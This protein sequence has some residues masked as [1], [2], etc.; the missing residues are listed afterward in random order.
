MTSTL[1]LQHVH[2]TLLQPNSHLVRQHALC[3]RH[4]SP[5]LVLQFFLQ[6]DTCHS[7]RCCLRVNKD[8]PIEHTVSQLPSE[9]SVSMGSTF[10]LA[11]EHQLP[12]PFK[13]KGT[14][15]LGSNRLN[16]VPES[17]RTD[18]CEIQKG[19]HHTTPQTTPREHFRQFKSPGTGNIAKSYRARLQRRSWQLPELSKIAETPPKLKAKILLGQWR[20]ST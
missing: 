7:K 1:E 8:S 20:T 13:V 12:A 14:P 17:R 15:S 4:D 19:I 16:V 11:N 9:W 18:Y 10:T 6:P 3:R 2:N 5:Q